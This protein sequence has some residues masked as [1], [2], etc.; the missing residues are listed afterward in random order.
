MWLRR[1]LAV[2]VLVSCYGGD[3]AG[4]VAPLE[5]VA[6]PGAPDPYAVGYS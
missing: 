2:L 1:T 3:H 4:P 5:R 6:E